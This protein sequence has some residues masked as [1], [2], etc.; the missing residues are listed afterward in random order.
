MSNLPVRT[1]LPEAAGATGGLAAAVAAA[2]V[3]GFFSVETA[4]VAVAGDGAKVLAVRACD[5][6]LQ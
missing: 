5:A 6:L 3:V 2:D 4:T 1:G